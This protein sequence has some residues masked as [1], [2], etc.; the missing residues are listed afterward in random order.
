[1]NR[2]L[3]LFTAESYALLIEAQSEAEARDKLD[4]HLARENARRRDMG[5]P[6]RA[7]AGDWT[8]QEEL[9]EEAEGSVFCMG[10]PLAHWRE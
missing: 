3:F 8:L 9:D 7:T 2:K 6:G 4:H 5:L 1:M 10:T